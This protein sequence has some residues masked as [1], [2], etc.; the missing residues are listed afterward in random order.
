MTSAQNARGDAK[1]PVMLTDLFIKK[2]NHIRR[3]TLI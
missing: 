2:K 3:E 1:E